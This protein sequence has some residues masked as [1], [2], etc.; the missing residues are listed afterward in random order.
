V[1]LGIFW[2]FFTFRGCFED[3]SDFRGILVILEIL[4]NFFI[5]LRGFGVIFGHF[6]DFMYFGQFM[7]F[8]ILNFK[9]SLV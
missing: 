6:G 3:F 5:Y 1:F 9:S 7:G 8:K 2:S 4:E